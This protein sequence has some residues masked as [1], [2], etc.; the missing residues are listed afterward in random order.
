MCRSAFLSITL[1]SVLSSKKSEP[2][3]TPESRVAGDR[4]KSGPTPTR[5]A[6]QSRNDHSLIVADRKAAKKAARERA[7]K[8][9]AER[10]RLEQEALITGDERYMPLR[11]KGVVKRFTRDWIDA[12]W[13]ASEFVFPVMIVFFV[14]FFAISFFSS[15]SEFGQRLLFIITLIMYGL[16]LISVVESTIVWQRIKRS[17]REVYPRERIPRRMWFYAF[18]RAIMLRPWRSP[19]PQVARGQFPTR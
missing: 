12:R 2:E 5:K 19:R 13:S 18:S 7:R 14:F 1:R 17:L 8:M 3:E 10:D 4:T 6:A 15:T 9:R 16:F 11:D